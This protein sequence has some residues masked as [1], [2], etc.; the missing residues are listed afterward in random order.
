MATSPASK[1]GRRR[2]FRI[3]SNLSPVSIISG[4]TASGASF[5]RHPNRPKASAALQPLERHGH[6]SILMRGQHAGLAGSANPPA[7]QPGE[8]DV[9][10]QFAQY[11]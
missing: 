2:R 1:E 9:Q 6:G 11:E 4:C 5:F 7:M 8:V 10:P 3:G